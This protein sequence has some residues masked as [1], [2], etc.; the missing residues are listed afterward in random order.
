MQG[1]G[2]LLLNG[3]NSYTGTTISQSTLEVVNGANLGPG[4]VTDNGSL[5]YNHHIG[6]EQDG[7]PIGGTGTVTVEN[8]SLEWLSG[9][10]TYSGGTTISSGTLEIGSY[11][12]LGTGPVTLND[13]NTGTSNTA[14]L[15]TFGGT[16]PIPNDITVANQGTGTTT[17]GTTSFT[18]TGTGAS[19]TVFGGNVALDRDVTFQGGNSM[20]TDWDGVISSPNG[21]VNVGVTSSSASGNLTNFGPNTNFTGNIDISGTGTT[22]QPSGVL[23]GSVPSF[24]TSPSK[25]IVNHSGTYSS[26]TAITGDD[27]TLTDGNGSEARSAFFNTVVPTTT[28]FTASFTYTAS[29]GGFPNNAADGV[30]FVLQGSSA[31][32]S[33]LGGQGGSLG[34]AGI[35][36]PALA[37]TFNLYPPAG[38]AGTGFSSTVTGTLTN[39]MQS[40]IYTSTSPVALNNGDAKFIVL[41]YNPSTESITEQLTDDIT[42][43]TD[44]ITIPNVNIA[45]IFGGNSA[46]VGFTGASGGSTATQTIQGFSLLTTPGFALSGS[47]NVTVGA[48]ANFQIAASPIN[49]N[50]L[51]GA[52][53]VESV[54]SGPA[55]LNVGVG[56]GS[57][58][59]T[60]TIKD[61]SSPLE[62]VQSGTGTLTL[63]GNNTYTGGTVIQ[64]DGTVSVSNGGAL[65]PGNI[66]VAG[67]STLDA[68]ASFTLNN[69]IG[70]GAG[71][72]RR[73]RHHRGRDRPDAHLWRHPRKYY[74]PSRALAVTPAA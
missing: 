35:S 27:L 44:T 61:G 37:V 36:G 63:S 15:S 5:V 55:Q 26:S 3:A 14:L 69:N 21:T 50:A 66:I 42:K 10:S 13:T 70:L 22:L 62:L 6:F 32:T 19:P 30:A 23:T 48:G 47:D 16:T 9:N 11:D 52:G 28:G 45:A 73:N 38:G 64:L 53:T 31:G 59:F 2:T 51:S 33:A 58:I 71:L 67:G 54:A 29:S 25:W 60:G 18:P 34:V 49:I 40:G 56:N 20:G 17:L 57:G 68:T 4:S 39:G 41:T 65:G 24:G 8:G 74:A 72:C 43:A 1:G 46:Y 7:N 12:A